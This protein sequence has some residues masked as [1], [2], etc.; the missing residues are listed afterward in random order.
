MM[1][2]AGSFSA[3][4]VNINNPGYR[5]FFKITQI[6]QP[7]EIFSFLD[8]HPDSIGDGYFL[9]K[10]ASIYGAG[11]ARVE[12]TEL[13]AS[14]HNSSAAFSFADGHSALHRWVDA[15]TIR[16]PQPDAAGLPIAINPYARSDFDW[17]IQHM[18]IGN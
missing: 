14:A 13:P 6:P 7:A 17:V 8:E 18:S 1:G 16:P 11:Y 4:G 15:S 10:A 5:Q 3:S 9:N 2:N 12:W